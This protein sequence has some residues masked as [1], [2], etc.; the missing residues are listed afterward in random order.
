MGVGPG[1]GWGGS[2]LGSSFP[3]YPGMFVQQHR[4]LELLNSFRERFGCDWLQYRSHLEVSGSP[5][6]TTS[7]TAALSTSSP[8]ALGP[9]T[10]PS[11]QASEKEAGGPKESEQKVAKQSR[12]EPEPQEEEDREEQRK[13]AAKEGQEEEEEE[14]REQQEVEG[15]LSTATREAGAKGC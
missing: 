6:Q 10:P 14:G 7:K 12:M 15:E 8:S 1:L 5:L 13:E 2:L 3:V 9:E 4:E 11:P